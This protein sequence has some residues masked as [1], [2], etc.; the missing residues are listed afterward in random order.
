MC[1]SPVGVKHRV[2]DA[3]ALAETLSARGFRAGPRQEQTDEYF[4]TIDGR[5]QHDD[6]VARVRTVGTQVTAGFKGPRSFHEDGTSRRVEI[7]FPAADTDTVHRALAAQHLVCVWRL[8]KRRVEYK[9]DGELIVALDELPEL[10][11]F[12]EFE[13]PPEEIAALRVHVRDAVGAPE[14]GNYA[15][16]AREW[17]RGQGRPL[18]DP[19][20][21][22]FG[23]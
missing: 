21:L 14:R 2:L 1:R 9:G 23:R 19:P 17:L 11:M 8:Q 10:G 6:F 7:E 12:V 3:D 5:F 18:P 16:L 13:G 4:D 22:A 15:E 20:G